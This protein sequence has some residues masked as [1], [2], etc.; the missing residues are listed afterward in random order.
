MNCYTN[1]L[2][3]KNAGTLDIASNTTYDSQLLRLAES[4][5][6]EIDTYTEQFYYIYEG[7]FYQDGGAN[8]VVLDWPVQTISSL[9]VDINGNNQYPTTSAYSVDINSPTTAPD[10]FCYPFNKYPKTR[11]EANPMGAFGHLG[12][13]FRKAIKITGTFGYGNDWPA[14]YTIDSGTVIASDLTSTAVSLTA[15]TPALLSAGM[16]LKLESEQCY[17]SAATSTS[18]TIQRAQNGTAAA[19]HASSTSIL[20]YDYPQ[21]IKQACLIQTIKLWKR[22]ESGFATSVGNNITGEYQTFRGLDADV[23]E[24]IREYKRNR[25]GTWL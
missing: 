4:A 14:S 16:T 12:A 2:T 21:P 8:R 5:S 6:R 10:A 1:L 19:S 13:G 11:L 24:I 22:R 18:A 9:I 3:L 23:K 17:V 7:T 25:I 15:S 20:V